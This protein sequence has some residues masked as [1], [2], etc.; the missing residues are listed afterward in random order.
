M[1][2]WPG[3]DSTRCQQ[4]GCSLLPQVW[5]LGAMSRGCTWHCGE[6]VTRR[7]GRGVPAESGRAAST[8]K[9]CDPCGARAECQAPGV[10]HGFSPSITKGA[11]MAVT[12]TGVCPP[13]AGCHRLSSPQQPPTGS[14]ITLRGHTIEAP[15][16]EDLQPSG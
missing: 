15:A 4:G 2:P 16:T 9:G 7:A 1:L 5:V 3:T 6:W 10:N 14:P 12:D 8:Q 11:E 13:L